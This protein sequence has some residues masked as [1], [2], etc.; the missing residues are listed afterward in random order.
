MKKT[1]MNRNEDHFILKLEKKHKKEKDFI[2]QKN[3]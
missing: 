3:Q 2:Y 1:T